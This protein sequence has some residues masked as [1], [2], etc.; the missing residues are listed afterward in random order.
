[1]FHELG[2]ESGATMLA[3]SFYSKV[4]LDPVLRPLFS[5][6][7]LRCA[8]EELAAF[9]VQFFDGDESRMQSRHWLSLRESHARFEIDEKHRTAWL[10]HMRSALS[11]R[12]PSPAALAALDDFFV[13]ASLHV[14]GQNSEAPRHGDL[15]VR[16]ARQLALD[17][18][19]VH[20]RLGRDHA[21]IRIA[22]SQ[23]SHS[24]VFVG[25]LA[26]MMEAGRQPLTE[27]VLTA[28]ESEPGLASRR[29]NGR[30][31]LHHA[32]GAACLPVVRSLLATGV[33]PDI[34]DVAG[35]SPLYRA[36]SSSRP[37]AAGIVR[38]LVRAGAD[39]DLARGV[40]RSTAL[41]EAARFGNAATVE[42]LLEAG[43]SIVATDRKG[44][45]PYERAVN[46]RRTLVASLLRPR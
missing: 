36:A 10:R 8:T 4:A 34:C 6:K 46:C 39:P 12:V 14:M 31:L 25:V 42:A 13:R 18:L 38:A 33:D 20:V 5:G 37:D 3:Q 29:F 32:A 17:E 45:T 30:S 40:M 19:A 9:L 27:F 15:A 1:M 26:Q 28:C 2:G 22:A 41:H 23:R 16:W 11:E 44:R 43:A 24:S 21:A 7:S 35:H